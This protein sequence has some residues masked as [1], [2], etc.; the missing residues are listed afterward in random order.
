MNELIQVTRKDTTLNSTLDIKSILSNANS[1]SIPSR[2]IGKNI[3]SISQESYTIIS[4]IHYLSQ[5]Q[6]DKLIT[7][8]INDSFQDPTKGRVCNDRNGQIRS[9][10]LYMFIDQICDLQNSSYLCLIPRNPL[11]K[12]TGGILVGVKFTNTGMDIR[13]LS[14]KRI[15]QYKFDEYYI[16]Q[17]LKEED[18]LILYIQAQSL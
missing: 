16:F 6:K 18:Q 10:S 5:E 8:L 4:S 11:K 12:Q 13:I 7:K 14:G 2:L 1:T 17:K 15:L 9:F 3:S